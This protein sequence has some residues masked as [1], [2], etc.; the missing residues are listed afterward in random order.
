MKGRIFGWLITGASLM[1]CMWSLNRL[2]TLLTTFT[3][4]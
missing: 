4:I 3:I 2:I 1:T